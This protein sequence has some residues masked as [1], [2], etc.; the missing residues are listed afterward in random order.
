MRYFLDTSALVKIYHKE[1]GSE[2]VLTVYKSEKII[3][4]ELSIV[5]LLSAVHR[6]YR[7]E[8]IDEL[9]LNA[10]C[11]KFTEDLET[12]YDVIPFSSVIIDKACN[13]IHKHGRW[14]SLR[15]LDSLQLAFFLIYCDK[16]EDAFLCADK[17]LLELAIAEDVLVIDVLTHG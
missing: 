3:I 7:E 6:K 15:T 4:S 13:L 8:E 1:E 16:Q 17:R 9:T 10:V 11:D 12:R 5:E 14:K 2:N